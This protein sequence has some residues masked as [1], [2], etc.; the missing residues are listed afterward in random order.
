MTADTTPNDAGGML[1]GLPRTGS[2]NSSGD[3][4]LNP[5]LNVFLTFRHGIWLE[6]IMV[7]IK[8]AC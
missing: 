6:V 7:R 3:S 1:L 2:G 8:D 5:Y 4:I